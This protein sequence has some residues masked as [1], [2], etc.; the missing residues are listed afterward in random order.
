MVDTG[1][2]HIQT[3]SYVLINQSM[4]DGCIVAA[5]AV[6]AASNVE[7]LSVDA[8]IGHDLPLQGVR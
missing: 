8:D 2:L 4:F 1:C 5:L 3:I 7:W 6:T